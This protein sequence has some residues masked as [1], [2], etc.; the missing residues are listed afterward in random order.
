VISKIIGNGPDLALIHGWGLDSAAWEPVVEILMQQCRVHLIDLA[1]Y[2]GQPTSHADFT[3][4]AQALIDSLPNGVTLCGWSLGGMLA[5]QAALLAP[6]KIA[7]LIL[8]GSTPSFMQRDNWRSAQAPDLLDT[9]ASAVAQNTATTLQRFIALLNQGDAQARPIS[10]ALTGRTLGNAL[11]DTET[12]TRGLDWLRSIDLR[13]Q[14]PA[15]ALPTLLIHG[16]RDP[17]MPLAAAHWLADQLPQARL[18]TFTNA[19]HAPFLADPERF[20]SLVGDFCHEK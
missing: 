14:I 16:E 11:P 10:R 2:G 7:R 9:F 19:A 12:L 15:I 6:Q 4:T 18:E 20:T 13:A 1:G 3:Q 8:V 5:L 17:L